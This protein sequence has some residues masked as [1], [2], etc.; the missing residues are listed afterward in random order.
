MFGNV[1]RFFGISSNVSFVHFMD[2]LYN[3][4]IL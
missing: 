2:E 4:Y 1:V 3:M